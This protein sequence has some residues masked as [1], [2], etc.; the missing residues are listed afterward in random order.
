MMVILD[1]GNSPCSIWRKTAIHEAWAKLEA[2]GAKGD[3]EP[4]RESDESDPGKNVVQWA[5]CADDEHEH[6]P[7]TKARAQKLIRSGK[8]EQRWYEVFMQRSEPEGEDASAL[9][10]DLEREGGPV[11]EVK[12]YAGTWW[13]TDFKPADET[14]PALEN[15]DDYVEYHY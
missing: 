6:E 7:R 2:M 12:E 15:F 14:H 13:I 1:C 4:D 11:D 9:K 5:I 3:S 8:K 10:V